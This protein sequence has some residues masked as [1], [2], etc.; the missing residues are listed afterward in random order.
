MSPEAIAMVD[1]AC[2]ISIFLWV[3]Y[4]L[5]ELLYR[6]FK[7]TPPSKPSIAAVLMAICKISRPILLVTAI[8]ASLF[9][10]V[11]AAVAFL[12]IVYGLLFIFIAQKI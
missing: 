6:G 11:G 2:D 3:C 8:I 7:E 10:P 1:E 4:I 9:T 12:A 5:I